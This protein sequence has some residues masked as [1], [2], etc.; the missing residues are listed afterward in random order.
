MP[1]FGPYSASKHA[2]VGL[3]RSAALEYAGKLRVNCINPATTMT[4][5]VERFSQRWPE[6]QVGWGVWG[7][8]GGSGAVDG[9]FINGAC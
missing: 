7:G 4:P 9:V 1:E 5:M 8:V 6:W 3:A 2:L